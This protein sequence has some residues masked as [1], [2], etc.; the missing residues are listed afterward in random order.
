AEYD[1]LYGHPPTRPGWAPRRLAGTAVALGYYALALLC[2]AGAG[3]LALR[4]NTLDLIL[5]LLVALGALAAWPRSA[6]L[7]RY[8]DRVRPD[9]AP[10]LYQLI[11]EVAAT[12]GARMPAVVCLD[13]GFAADGGTY[14]LRRRRYLVLGLP[15]WMVLPPAQ[16]VALLAHQLAH[17]VD[18]DPRRGWPVEP[19][20]HM[21]V[22]GIALLVPGRDTT[23]QAVR[24][25]AIVAAAAGGRPVTA[26]NTQAMVWFTELIVVPV[27][28]LLRGSV[29]LARLALVAL[30]QRDTQ[31]AEYLADALAARAAGSAAS[32]AMLDLMLAAE[33]VLTVLRSR[34]RSGVP[35]E[36]WPDTVAAAMAD[37][38][39]RLPARRQHSAQGEVSP[40]AAHPPLGL[41]AQMIE[42]RPAVP[43]S[44]TLDP[45]RNARIDAELRRFYQRT[46][47]ELAH[48][49]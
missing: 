42:S 41:R 21:L 39:D 29:T 12:M 19:V 20:D 5:G 44:V 10:A 23:I 14:G 16:R 3:W 37:G 36:S 26:T 33:P 18:G 24:D 1:A 15:L 28:G 4:G 31:R 11:G 45:D 47:R 2:L 17:F 43:G 22:R 48:G 9:A 40:F 8:A 27:F 25:P 49:G 30:V 46:G 7:P 6:R 35:P 13:S 38:A 32:T 34:A